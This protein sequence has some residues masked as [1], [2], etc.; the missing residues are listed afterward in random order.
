MALAVFVDAATRNNSSSLNDIP[1]VSS[2]YNL[3]VVVDPVKVG[4]DKAFSLSKALTALTFA[5]T[6]VI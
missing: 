5:L 3:F 1:S 6:V 2:L 4:I